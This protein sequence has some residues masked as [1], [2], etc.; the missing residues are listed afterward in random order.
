M[1]KQLMCVAAGLAVFGSLVLIQG[2]AKAEAQ[3]STLPEPVRDIQLTIYKEDFA[4]VHEARPVSLASG[5]NELPM[6]NVS[7]SLDPNTVMFD[8]QGAANPPEVTSETY[9][10]GVRNGGSLLKRLEGKPV[11]MLWNSQDGKPHDKIEGTLE[12]AQDGGFVIRADDKLYVNPNGTIVASGEQS[13]VTMPQ[14]TAT[15]ESP[16]KQDAKVGFVYQTRGMSWSADYVG[17]LTQDGQAMTMECWATLENHTGIDYPNA[18]I[19]LV[20]GTPNRATMSAQGRM[21]KRVYEDNAQGGFSAHDSSGIYLNGTIAPVAVGE[22]YAYKVP[23]AANVG[24]E[25]MNRV[26]MIKSTRVPVKRD[27]NIRL[28]PATSYDGG[29]D[30]QN[31]QRQNAQLAISLVNDEKSGLGLPLP[32]GAVRVYDDSPSQTEA[33]IGAASLGDTPKNQHVNLTLSKVID[34]YSDSRTVK[35]Q[36]IDK[37]TIR[38]TFEAVLHNEKKAPVD[39]RVVQSFSGKKHLVIE[40]D[41]GVQLDSDTRQWTIYVDAGGQKKL[42]WTADF[43]G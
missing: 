35:T 12:A 11:E 18:T 38:K 36:R 24:Q 30:G 26:K 6:D 33:Y 40:S 42:T 20:A 2:C 22:L 17:R 29:Y 34:V 9:D 14:L 41:K 23:A 10:L 28:D 19:T 16:A 7:K 25:Q 31:S 15:V 8:W 39:M 37:R 1:T 32:A 5:R 43:S 3:T 4:L 13:L 21:A 27:Y